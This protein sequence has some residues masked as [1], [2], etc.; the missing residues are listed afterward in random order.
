MGHHSVLVGGGKRYSGVVSS[1]LM[2]A[3]LGGLVQWGLGVGRVLMGA[4]RRQALSGVVVVSMVE[5]SGKVNA[6]ITPEDR[7][8]EH[9]GG[10]I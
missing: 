10:G 7:S 2:I 5:V 4:C 1:A 6:W 8:S 3:G 9:G